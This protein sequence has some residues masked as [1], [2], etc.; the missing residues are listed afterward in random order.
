M[1]SAPGP[2]WDITIWWHPPWSAGICR[3][4][5]HRLWLTT[6]SITHRSTGT[7]PQAPRCSPRPLS[8]FSHRH[9]LRSACRCRTGAPNA[10]CPSAWPPTSFSTCAP[11]TRKNSRRSLRWRSAER[12]NSPARFVTNTSESDTTCHD[13]WLLTTEK[14]Q[15]ENIF[16]S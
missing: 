13:T 6:L 2:F 11:I 5:T 14:M 3:L 10:T 16:I 9:S 1:R 8:P 7:G 4:P 15:Q 12:R